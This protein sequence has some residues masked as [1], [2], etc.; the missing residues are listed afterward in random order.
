MVLTNEV[1]TRLSEHLLHK[2]EAM[3]EASIINIG[4]QLLNRI[5]SLHALGYCHGNICPSS[6]YFC[7]KQKTQVILADF[8]HSKKYRTSSYLKKSMA[9]NKF[10]SVFTRKIESE[11]F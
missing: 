7:G 9:S 5:E 10:E 6:I 4:L 2:P 11:S 1:G 8:H 3:N